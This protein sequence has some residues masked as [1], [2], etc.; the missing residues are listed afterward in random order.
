MRTLCLFLTTMFSLTAHAAPPTQADLTAI[1]WNAVERQLFHDVKSLAPGLIKNDWL[2]LLRNGCDLGKHKVR[3][4]FEA[5]VLRNTPY[6]LKGYDFKSLG[7]RALFRADGAWY[8]KKDRSTPTFEPKVGACIAKIKA[9]EKANAA[10][11]KTAFPRLKL[12][13]ERLFQSR[14]SYLRIR[15]FNHDLGPGPVRMTPART[16]GR[17]PDMTTDVACTKCKTGLSAYKVVCLELDDCYV[18][19]GQP[20][21]YEG[22][23]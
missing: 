15:A 14:E 4:P 16:V 5:S 3:T 6:A 9:F 18:S 10:K 20:A 19:Q 2:A 12:F 17:P 8:Q 7:L 13:K 23:Q 1:D 22:P 11:W 21:D